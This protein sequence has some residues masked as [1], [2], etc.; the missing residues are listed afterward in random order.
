MNSG[1]AAHSGF[2]SLCAVAIVIAVSQSRA[3]IESVTIDMPVSVAFYVL[4]MSETT[5]GVPTPTTFT[6]TAAHLNTGH[7]MR[8]SAKAGATTFAGPSG[9]QIPA[10]NISW[11]VS[12]ASGGSG[13]AGM[14]DASS[15]RDLFDSITNPSQGRC[16]I[17]F[18]LA[19]LPAHVHAGMHSLNIVWKVE[20]LG[21]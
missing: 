1:M 14:L 20:S 19:P 15:Y 7:S 10:S 13:V 3:D 11:S 8:I 12:G 16:D 6:F 21:Y 4:D 9:T 5:V 17:T 18:K 2:A